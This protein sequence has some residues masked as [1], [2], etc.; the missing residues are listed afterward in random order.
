MALAAAYA[1]GARGSALLV[2]AALLA[3]TS[4]W[5]A[6]CAFRT[7]YVRLGPKQ[8]GGAG[9]LALPFLFY[10]VGAADWA[11]WS[12]M[13]VAL[14][15]GLHALA[16]AAWC[17]LA[18]RAR[19]PRPRSAWAFGGLGVLLVATRPEALVTVLWFALS[20]AWVTRGSRVRT[21]LAA[22]L[23]SVGFVLLLG[24]VNRVATGESTAYGALVKLAW[25][26]PTLSLEDK[27]IDYRENL[28]HVLRAVFQ[29]HVGSVTH[30]GSLLIALAVLGLGDRARRKGVVLLWLQCVSWFLLVSVNGQVRWQNE[31]Y[32]MPAVAWL[33]VLAGYGVA[34]ARRAPRWAWALASAAGLATF[35]ASALPD[36][37]ERAA[38]WP[39]GLEV[40]EGL[41]RNVPVVWLWCVGF[42]LAA[43]AAAYLGN[44]GRFV[45][46]TLAVAALADVTE[47]NVRTQRWFFGRAS[48]NI[49]EQQARLGV[50]LREQGGPQRGRV[51]VGDAGAILYT[52]DWKGLDLIG[53]GG[54]HDLPFARA[55]AFGLGASL[56]L[57]ERV[58]V[59]DRP[60]YLAIF[61][62]WWESLPLFFTQEV[63]KRFP[64]EGNVICGDFEH[65][66]YRADWSLLRSGS[67][68]RMI[69]PALSV[70]DELDTGDLVSEKQHAYGYAPTR[71]NGKVSFK[72][73][74]DPS[75]HD[76][77]DAGRGLAMGSHEHFVL[78][79]ADPNARAFVFVRTAPEGLQELRVT[80]AGAGM[81]SRTQEVRLEETGGFVET[82]FAVDPPVAPEI[83]VDVQALG[84]ADLVNY[85]VYLAQ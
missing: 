13:E 9:L 81:A 63:V 61:P 16:Y 22:A 29:T 67:S 35:F 42:V 21:A 15:V 64:I 25:Y 77:F 68:P 80:I 45:A 33:L 50:W 57:L 84:P 72:I 38:R 36:V 74:R 53:L 75:E 73:L 3:M 52:S 2:V 41:G 24:A 70:L 58:P 20:L 48:K 49:L 18:A 8:A 43:G 60:D 31:R 19:S 69:P 51:L 83:T 17:G 46:L 82:P 14:F 59:R 5:G 79:G 71:K 47:P 66:V 76:L 1:V 39:G 56:E 7:G 23:P 10:A 27:W 37:Y 4:C 54:Y 28:A 34:S 12:G 65:V 30:A 62:S 11:F 6:L 55:G 78:R 44:A 85:H 40:L 26:N 32:A